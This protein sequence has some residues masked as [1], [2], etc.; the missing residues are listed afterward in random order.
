MGFKIKRYLD[1]ILFVLVVL[2]VFCVVFEN[3]LVVPSWVQV[4]GRMHPLVLH[5]PIVLLL[6]YVFLELFSVRISISK[7]LTNGVLLVASLTAT[8]TALAGL[9]LSRESG[10]DSDALFAHKWWGV[11]AA[12]ISSVL[13]HTKNN[14]WF[15]ESLVKFSAVLI[16]I[17]LVVA[18]HFG[19]NVT[20]GS[21]FLFEPIMSNVSLNDTVSFK[22]AVMYDHVIVPIFKSKC[23]SCHNPEKKK[24]KLDLTTKEA[25]LKGGEDGKIVLAG[26]VAESKLTH[27][28]NLPLAHDDHMPPEGKAQLTHQEMNLLSQWVRA[29]ADMKNKVTAISSTD[30]LYMAAE[31]IWKSSHQKKLEAKYTFDAANPEEI[32]NLN[33]P[34]RSVVPLAKE[35][36]ALKVIFYNK[37][38]FSSAMLS[39]LKTVRNNIVELDLHNMPIQNGDMKMISEFE[40]L[41]VLNLNYTEIGNEGL[42]Y[43]SSLKQLQR[44]SLSGTSTSAS[45][46][47]MLSECIALK[48][49]F[50][51]NTSVQTADITSLQK[52]FNQVTFQTGFEDDGAILKLPPPRLTNKSVVFSESLMI[53]LSNPIQGAEMR[54]TINDEKLD[55]VSG[56]VYSAKGISLS[57]STE[58]RAQAFK[59]GWTKSDVL[60]FPVVR[61]SFPPD[62]LSFTYAPNPRYQ[63]RGT[64][65]L[66][67]KQLAQPSSWHPGWVGFYEKPMEL[68]L[69]YLQPV[70]VSSVSFSCLLDIGGY[71]FPPES[72]EV[73]GGTNIN[74]LKRITS[75]KPAQPTAYKNNQRYLL[76][77]TFKPEH[78]SILKI[79]AK[80][81]HALPSWHSSKGQ[82]GHFFVDELGVN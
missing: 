57:Q 10:Y 43:L 20:H 50:I 44:L 65:S 3:K 59:D 21:D 30:S 68:V 75:I 73:W 28:I 23:F 17:C 38:S 49:I 81:I 11:G 7:E 77:Y 32:K 56:L 26:N 64:Q 74:K 61:N 15:K 58:I 6:V 78:V 37:E 62:Q 70:T 46:I 1:N 27:V 66:I 51:W 25:F 9:L 72:V 69:T 33:S 48:E 24:G 53:E 34:N 60:T 55:S 39:E 18:G 22:H 2:L 80:P 42:K 36:P 45:D 35:S 63:G 71:I 19:S 12:F 13:Y 41:E 14:T 5:F 54:Y 76:N 31:S 4:V 67:D 82:R 52:Q 8:F 16:G 79:I 29:G 47:G 40:N